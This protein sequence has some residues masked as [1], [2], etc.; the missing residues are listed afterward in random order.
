LQAKEKDS[1][2]Y[3]FVLILLIGLPLF[4]L[5]FLS[6]FT[7]FPEQNI[8][9]QNWTGYMV[10][11]DEFEGNAVN[12]SWIVPAVNVSAG[13]SYSSIWIGIGGQLDNTLI[14]LG[15]MRVC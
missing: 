11:S 5:E 7:G 4:A 15:L 2:H 13:D 12:A 1:K 3:V 14:Q 9:N 8:T 10:V 6:L